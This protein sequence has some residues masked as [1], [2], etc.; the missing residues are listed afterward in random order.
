LA[1]LTRAGGLPTPA[2]RSLHRHLLSRSHNSSS[3]HEELYPT[4]PTLTATNLNS[5]PLEVDTS[6]RPSY[7][8]LLLAALNLLL[9]SPPPQASSRTAMPSTTTV[10]HANRVDHSPH[11]ASKIGRRRSA[12]PRVRATMPHNTL[13]PP[14]RRSVWCGVGV[15]EDHPSPP[16]NPTGHEVPLIVHRPLR[17]NTALSRHHPSGAPA[18]AAE[19]GRQGQA[20]WA[21]AVCGRACA[22]PRHRFPRL[23]VATARNCVV[24]KHALGRLWATYHAAGTFAAVHA[25][26]YSFKTRSYRLT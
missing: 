19:T 7:S 6:A 26:R 20:V 1:R 8:T 24:R 23:L 21:T 16:P 15:A 12:V 2:I 4:R 14:G 10:L 11:T 9:C 5:P 25:A 22:A 3:I 13:K 17:A 18:N